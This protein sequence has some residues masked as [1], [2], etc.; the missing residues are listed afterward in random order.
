MKKQTS[1]PVKEQDRIVQRGDALTRGSRSGDDR[2]G[3]SRGLKAGRR[4]EDHHRV[5]RAFLDRVKDMKAMGISP[6]ST[7]RI[8]N[9]EGETTA[10]GEAWTEAAIEQLLRVA[11]ARERR[12]A[13][14]PLTESDNS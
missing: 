11:E 5:R 14:S 10:Q 8:L 2:R 1:K 9:D 6:A 4:T 13:W 7:A 3:E 12:L